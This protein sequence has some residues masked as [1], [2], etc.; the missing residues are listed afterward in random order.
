M[1]RG[2]LRATNPDRSSW[3][4]NSSH[5]TLVLAAD[6]RPDEATRRPCEVLSETAHDVVGIQ[7]EEAGHESGEIPIALSPELVN[8]LRANPPIVSQNHEAEPEIDWDLSTEGPTANHQSGVPTDLSA[9]VVDPFNP[10]TEEDCPTATDPSLH[11]PGSRYWLF[12]WDGVFRSHLGEFPSSSLESVMQNAAIVARNR[13]Q[14]TLHRFERVHQPLRPG[15]TEKAPV[16]HARILDFAEP[17]PEYGYYIDPD[18]LFLPATP[19]PSSSAGPQS[20]QSRHQKNRDR[21]KQQARTV[22][23]SVRHKHSARLNRPNKDPNLSHLPSSSSHKSQANRERNRDHLHEQAKAA[24]EAVEPNPVP[25][26]SSRLARPINH[27]NLTHLSSATN[28]P[29]ATPGP[30]SPSIQKTPP[31]SSQERNRDRLHR[32]AKVALGAGSP[33]SSTSSRRT[34]L[35]RS[36]NPA[37]LSSSNCQPRARTRRSRT[38]KPNN[39]GDSYSLIESSLEAISPPQSSKA[40]N[41]QLPSFSFSPFRLSFG[42]RSGATSRAIRGVKTGYYALRHKRREEFLRQ[43][44]RKAIAGP[45]LRGLEIMKSYLDGALEDL[46]SFEVDFGGI[47]QTG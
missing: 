25:S 26:C 36:P 32:Q 30:S 27:P 20:T 14:P 17:E 12:S 40:S 38:P 34:R 1:K 39:R 16:V 18:E 5:T 15:P 23:E 19:P 22:L 4:A 7:G 21:L 41:H 45:G 33:S 37:H 44:Y 29:S 11:G 47:G 24:L 42:S 9:T 10:I 28:S 46:G 2:P 35:S 6:V 43:E 13:R 31:K 3:G 8:P